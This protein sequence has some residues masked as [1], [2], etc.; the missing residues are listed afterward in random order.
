MSSTIF[1]FST[2]FLAFGSLLCLASSTFALFNK[3]N[4][5]ASLTILET[6]GCENFISES[7]AI[8]LSDCP[9]FFNLIIF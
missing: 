7:L 8:A 3:P 5:S 2:I 1:S 4:L 6:L 9:S